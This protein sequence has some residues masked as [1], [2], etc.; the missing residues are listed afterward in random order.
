MLFLPLSRKKGGKAVDV[1]FADPMF[2]FG[3]LWPEIGA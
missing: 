1:F 2:S 3:S